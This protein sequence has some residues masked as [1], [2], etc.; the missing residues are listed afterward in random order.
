MLLDSVLI[1]KKKKSTKRK[2]NFVN[3]T[4]LVLESL[5][6]TGLAW[7]EPSIK[8]TKDS[9]LIVQYLFTIVLILE[10]I[11]HPTSLAQQFLFHM[12]TIHK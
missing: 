10:L 2:A 1:K 8:T 4:V 9:N 6:S 5:S 3:R 7:F 11:S 12:T